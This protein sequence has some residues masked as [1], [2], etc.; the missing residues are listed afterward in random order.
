MFKTLDD[1]RPSGSTYG[2]RVTEYRYI[3]VSL[4]GEYS[5]GAIVDPTTSIK[6]LEENIYTPIADENFDNV[7]KGNMNEPVN[8]D[9]LTDAEEDLW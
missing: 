1:F 6:E 9:G 5:D 8:D 7:L 3:N 4:R 2:N